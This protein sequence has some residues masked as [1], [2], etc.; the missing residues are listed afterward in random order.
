MGRGGA[1]GAPMDPE[2]A[3]RMRDALRDVMEPSDRLTIV[4]SG[5]IVLITGADGRTSRLSPDGKSIKDE[6]TGVARK[7]RWDA[8]RLVSEITGLGRGKVTQTFAVDPE[9]HQLRVT[10][11]REG[12]LALTHVYENEKKGSDRDLTLLGDRHLNFS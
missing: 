1:R 4:Q 7:T 12:G 3:A 5:S 9:T 2:A 10:V 6:N 11:Q 8:G